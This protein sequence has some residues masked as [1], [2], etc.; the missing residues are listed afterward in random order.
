MLR[1]PPAGSIC[2]RDIGLR[3]YSGTEP[4]PPYIPPPLFTRSGEPPWMFPPDRGVKCRQL[5]LLVEAAGAVEFPGRGKLLEDAPGD[6][7]EE[8][9]IPPLRCAEFVSENR[10]HP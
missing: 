8:R 3:W 1:P 7:P 10:R 5:S 2:G 4:R 9:F 6:I